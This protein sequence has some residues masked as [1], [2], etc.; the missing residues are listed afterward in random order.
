M[1][2]VPHLDILGV[3]LSV[4]AGL[5]LAVAPARGDDTTYRLPPD[6]IVRMVD[7]PP[8]PAAMVV[9]GGEV[10]ALVE[11]ASPPPIRDLAQPMLRLAGYRLNPRTNGPF[12]TSYDTGIT[13]LRI[14]DGSRITVDVPDDARL[15]FPAWSPDGRR[16]AFTNTVDDGIELWVGE[17]DTGAARRLLG[18]VLNEAG[19]AGFAWMPDGRH[20]VCRVV[21]DDHGAPPAADPVPAGPV[22]QENRGAV[23]PV[24]TYQD[25]LTG[26]DDE[27][28]FA[29]LM[30]ARLVRVDV[31]TGART[32]LGGPDL[33]TRFA[34]SPNGRYLLVARLVR[35][36]SY[37]VPAWSFP[38]IV[39][40][41]SADDGAPVRRLAELP[42]RDTT[43]IG[44]VPTG[45]RGHRWAPVVDGAMVL[46]SEALDGGDPDRVVPHRDRLLV[47]DQP[48]EGEADEWHRTEHRFSGLTWL[49][50]SSLCLVSEYDRDRRWTRTWLLGPGS[51]DEPV[52][53]WDRSVRDRYGDPGRPVMK[54]NRGG[55]RVARA[56]GGKVLLAGRGATP[57]GDR[58]FL[59]RYDI[60]TGMTERRWRSGD[61]VYESVVDVI[62]AGMITRRESPDDPPNYFLRDA[63]AGASRQLTSFED[64][65]PELR[66]IRREL[67]TYERSDGVQLSATL[68]LPADHEPGTRLPLLVW[69]YPIEFNDPATAGQV[70]GSPHRFTRIRGSSHLFLL[71]QGYAIMDAATMPV[72]GD[73]ETMNDTFLD[74]I[75]ASAQAAIDHADALGVG[76]PDRVG[77]GGHSYG[78]FM[79]AN[80]LAHCDLFRAGVARSGAY[81][82]TLTPFGFQSERRTLWEAPE[83]YFRI[84][85][86]MHADKVNEPLLLIHGEMDNNSGTFPLQS[87]R[88]FHALKGHGATTRLV[89]LPYESHGYRGRESV[90]HVIAEMIDWFDRH[91]KHA[92]SRT[93]HGHAHGH[94]GAHA[95][96]HR[97]ASAECVCDAARAEHGWCAACGVGYVGG[98]AV[99]SAILFD[100]IDPHGHEYRP[101]SIDCES[102]RAAMESGGWC[103]ACGRGFEGDLLYVSRISHDLARGVED[104]DQVALLRRAVTV[105]DTRCETCAAAMLHDGRC[106]TCGVQYRGG[107]PVE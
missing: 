31:E 17:T 72:I 40:V 24:R 65:T 42:L 43:P 89:M 35:P 22:V 21:P 96:A 79:T 69:A 36:F 34:P 6:D 14:D 15:G 25:L 75:V 47:L 81:N 103:D 101:A 49:E 16:F 99:R 58:P 38:T 19:G 10:L 57:A 59:D 94:D 44:G 62:G 37:L 20:L 68:Y 45:P 39:E 56:H 97:D 41:W 93:A 107:S 3:V 102:C 48:F 95:H 55:H 83:S 71:T 28:L 13:L 80:L 46:W 18:P 73:P 2:H 70:S 64:P 91:V 5:L 86:F 8:T 51:D 30:T 9:P 77:V 53:V 76:D 23:S 54:T 27:A 63:A 26:P 85:P 50:R 11:Q 92:P 33:Y 1:T 84:S 4:M 82:R 90:L 52:L 98:V 60:A 106:T 105:A 7:A 74:Q 104:P 12:R 78:A 66:G 88:M 32:T 61:G 87:R 67:V 29:H 100:A